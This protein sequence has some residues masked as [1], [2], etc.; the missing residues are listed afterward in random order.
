MQWSNY[1]KAIFEDVAKGTGH[2]IVEALAGSGKTASIME[3]LNH[4]PDGSTWLLVAFNKKIA[5]ALKEKAPVFGGSVLT[6]H[7]LGL[8]SLGSTFKNIKIDNEKLDKIIESVLGDRVR[9]KELYGNLSNIV[10]L[11]KGYLASTPEAIDDLLD[12]K[13]LDLDEGRE[14]FIQYVLT[15]L[16]KCKSNPSRVDFDDMVWLPNVLK[17]K[18]P[19]FDRVFIDEA[20]DLNRAQIGLAIQACRPKPKTKKSRPEGR[21]FAYGDAHQSIYSFSGADSEAINYIRKL[22]NAKSLPLS[23]TYRCPVEVVKEAQRYVPHLEAAPNAI[24]G[25]VKRISWKEMMDLAKPGCFILSRVNAPLI[26][27]ALQFLQKGIPCNI[28]GRDL[29]QNLINLIER[30]KAKSL[31]GL[32]KWI[33]KWS[34]KEIKRLKDKNKDTTNIEDKAECVYAL[35]DVTKTVPELLAHL[36]K[37][38]TDT[39]DYN[40]IILSTTHKA[41]GLERDVVF[42]LTSTYRTSSQEEKNLSYVAITRAKKEL[43]F[44]GKKSD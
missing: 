33:Q 2:T 17:V 16:D 20:Q 4:I 22:L 32:R 23:I 11:A 30:S 21:I 35:C 13:E 6:L 29:G 31:E 37:I 36:R 41:K 3:S 18:V 1:Q 9:E 15:V 28:Q 39:D 27:L 42:M 40:K 43:Y 26:G 38:F 5:E 44:V 14:E 24:Q 7:A 12:L 25:Q 19:Q 34:E 8:K 10:S